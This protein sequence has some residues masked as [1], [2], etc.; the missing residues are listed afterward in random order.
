M[1]LYWNIEVVFKKILSLKSKVLLKIISE[2]TIKINID[3]NK[4][5]NYKINI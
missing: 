5:I 4:F 1:K 3:Y 2:K